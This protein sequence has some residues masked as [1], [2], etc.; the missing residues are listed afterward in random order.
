MTQVTQ[1]FTTHTQTRKPKT[2]KRGTGESPS[3]Q[4]SFVL[5]CSKDK[6]KSYSSRTVAQC[7]KM[8]SLT[9][10]NNR[11][12]RHV[13]RWCV[14]M[15]ASAFVRWFLCICWFLSK[16]LF[17]S[18]Y[19]KGLDGFLFCTAI[20]RCH[21]SFLRVQIYIANTAGHINSPTSKAAS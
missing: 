20:P 14:S 19:H 7:V 8:N 21:R 6:A 17:F 9:L 3:V 16:F 10:M 15:C 2:I 18:R 11:V 4:L 5:F 13:S 1:S 12:Q